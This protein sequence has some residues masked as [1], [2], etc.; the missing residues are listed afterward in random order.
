MTSTMDDVDRA[1]WDALDAALAA[2]RGC[3]DAAGLAEHVCPLA[4]EACGA[5][6]ASLDL[7][8][9]G[10]RTT[11]CRAGATEL[12]EA[13]RELPHGRGR[14]TISVDV[15]GVGDWLLDLVVPDE[16]DPEVAA[17]F[18]GALGSTMALVAVLQKVDQQRYIL[19]RVASGIGDVAEHPVEMTETEPLPSPSA[20]GA[21]ADAAVPPPAIRAGLSPRQ[22]EVLD[23]MLRG[24]SNAQIAERLVV[25]VPTVKSHVRA[26]LR[27]SGSVNRAE[28]ISRLSGQ[29]TRG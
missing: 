28:A 19:A 13:D 21:V 23:L 17:C 1:P 4:L 22:R 16:A 20:R 29:V 10:V 5:D 18:A 6:A 9:D 25:T 3:R 15:A 12:L 2:L 24:L 14:R 8:R 11:W 26:V 7:V 27:A